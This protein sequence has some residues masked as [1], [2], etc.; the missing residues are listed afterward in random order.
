MALRVPQSFRSGDHFRSLWKARLGRS[1]LGIS[2]LIYLRGLN[3]ALQ[4][5]VDRQ[6]GDLTDPRRLMACRL[7]SLTPKVPTMIVDLM[8]HF[9]HL[10]PTMKGQRCS[11]NFGL[12]LQGTVEVLLKGCVGAARRLG[13]IFKAIS[14]T[15]PSRVIRSDIIRNLHYG[16]LS[17][18]NCLGAWSIRHLFC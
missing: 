5:L 16:V 11:S 7:I 18:R 1:G 13:A 4:C 15:A 2:T 14:A 10:Y 6:Y 9:R 12:H 17:Q 3:G 8:Q